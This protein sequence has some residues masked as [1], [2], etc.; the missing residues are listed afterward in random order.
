MDDQKKFLDTLA[1]KTAFKFGLFGGLAI[2]FVIGFFILLGLVVSGKTGNGLSLGNNNNVP[3]ANNN[4][5]T[6]PTNTGNVANAKEVSKSDWVR[7]DSKAPITI[8]EYTDIDCPFCQR[9]HET[10]LDIMEQYDGEVNWVLRHFPLTSLHPNAFTKA[11]ALECA[12]DLKGNDV[13]W[14][15]TDMLIE[16]K[17]ITVDQLA[18]KAA[19]LGVDKSK[20]QACLD[21]HK[22]AQK[23]QDQANEAISAGGQGTPYSVIIAGKQ[24]MPINGALPIEQIT[25][26]L[27]SLLK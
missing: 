10:M 18:D 22:F 7:G 12:G 2:M 11:E 1:P 23:V 6:Q 17:T 14:Q 13:F 9:F 4:A 3:S 24:R 5:P 8:V 27:D 25:P 21:D 26:Q 16:D 19:S 15:F 20:F